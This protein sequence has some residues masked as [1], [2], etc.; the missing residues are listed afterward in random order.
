M[1][2][3]TV[4]VVEDNEVNREL[5]EDLL[6]VAGYAV[7][8]CPTGEQAMAWLSTNL[9]D[10]ILMDI[11]LPGED[12]LTLTRH[13]KARPETAG[14]PVVALT[15]Y[16]MS[17]DQERI[18]AAGCDGYISKPIDVPRFAAQVARHLGPAAVR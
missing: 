7:V 15:A 10:L 14:I 1:H 9:P 12:G 11:N 5:V 4:L 8:A 17:G 6:A 2:N 13:I 18:L 3:A 16:A